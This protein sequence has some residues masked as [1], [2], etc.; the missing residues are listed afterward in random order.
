MVSTA[1]EEIA[2]GA[3]TQAGDIS[4]SSQQVSRM[5][6]NMY[7]IT[8]SVGSLTDTSREMSEKGAEA[9]MIVQELSSTSDQTTDAFIK[10]SEQIHKTNASVVKI[11]EV[12]NLIAEVA[13]QTNLLSLNASIEAARAGEAG[14]GFAVVASEI[15]KLAEQTNSSA[16]VI[17]DIILT[18]S[19]ESQ[20]TVLSINEVTDM[21]MNQKTKLDE[22]RMKF[23]V[24]E[25]GICAAATGM[26]TVQEQADV[27]GRSGEHVVSLMT[28]LSA[29][30][31][32]NAATTEQTNAS[33]NDLNDATASLAR[34]A[35]ELK[36]LSVAVEENL[37]YF[38]TEE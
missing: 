9:A 6:E 17:D 20:E 31:E 30:A 27:C 24:V 10:I 36:K 34:T 21:I 8:A 5:Q 15:Q 12:V 35:E 29:I 1:L 26:K 14:R 11:Q 2:Q 16:K 25:E 28:N 38:V 18:L 33:M 13:S 32:E 3:A 7:Q 4:D 37:N 19:K 23:G 22:T